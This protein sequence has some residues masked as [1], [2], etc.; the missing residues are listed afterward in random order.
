[1]E[2]MKS[3]TLKGDE[4]FSAIREKLM[5]L[6]IDLESLNIA[7]QQLV[8]NQHYFRNRIE[9]MQLTLTSSTLEHKKLEGK[10]RN[11]YRR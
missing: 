8:K 11:R 1:M 10:P 7:K 2:E 4:V 5:C 3:V 6:Q 9:E